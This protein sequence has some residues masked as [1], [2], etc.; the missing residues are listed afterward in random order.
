MNAP[1]IWSN[2]RVRSTPFTSRIESGD[3]RV[4][5]YTV[6]NHMLLPLEFVSVVDDYWHL[7][8]HVQLWDVA[9]QR[10]VE[11]VGPDAARLVQMMT[12]RNLSASKVGRCYYAPL[13]DH[14]G[15]LLAP[16]PA[17]DRLAERHV[18]DEQDRALVDPGERLCAG[19]LPGR[20][21][22]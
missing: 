1:R 2:T 16:Q 8:E 19:L 6:Y 12:P 11:I 4:Q 14:R 22:G 3:V 15:G 5:A 17:G 13:V 21:R 9:V 18:D 7:K 20:S 10:Q